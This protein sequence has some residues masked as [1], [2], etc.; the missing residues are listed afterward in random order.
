MII[1][2]KNIFK[3]IFYLSLCY[4]SYLMILITLQYIPL[5]LNVAFLNVKEDAIQ[6]KHYQYAFF[7]HVYTSIFV[8]IFGLTQFSKSVRARFPKIHKYLGKLYIG[9]VLLVASPS[10]LIMAFYANGGFWSQLS[11]TLQAVLWFLFTFL[12]YKYVKEGKWKLH[13]KFMIR[14]YALTLSAI[15]LRLF[16]WIIVFLF[17]PPPMD[18]Y[19]VVAWL[20]WLIN[21]LIVELYFMK[22]MFK[23]KKG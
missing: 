21:L 13:Q 3:I 17:E 16:K 5:R 2:R 9:L 15:S 1:S 8:L 6:Y 12:A 20:G 22:R 23:N 19:K 11:F 14:S 18:T 4:F 10:G 7:S